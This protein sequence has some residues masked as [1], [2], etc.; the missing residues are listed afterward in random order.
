M[1]L[2]FG[3]E[4][5]KKEFLPGMITGTHSVGFSLTE[6]DHGSDATWLE[7]TATRDGSD[8]I[9]NG[10]KRF[11]SGLHDANWDMIFARSSGAP[12]EADGISCFQVPT[13]SPGFKVDFMWWTFNMPSDHAEVS[14][15]NV[16]VPSSTLFGEEGRGS[17]SLRPSCTR[18]GFAR[19][20]PV[21]ARHSSASTRAFATRRSA[22]CSASRSG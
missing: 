5:Q 2:R 15:E 18:T 12:G 4:E 11:N 7:T 22:R 14:L 17:R 6:P 9:L 1:M 3:S 13:D 8:W 16:R 20:P 10:T 21:S 19:R